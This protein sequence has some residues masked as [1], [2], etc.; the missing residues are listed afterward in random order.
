MPALLY[1]LLLFSPQAAFSYSFLGEEAALAAENPGYDFR[2]EFNRPLPQESFGFS[3]RQAEL[4]QKTR[5]FFVEELP[6]TRRR[7]APLKEALRAFFTRWERLPL[8]SAALISTAFS[9]LK[10][11]EKLPVCPPWGACLGLALL[12]PWISRLFSIL[13]H[14]ER[15]YVLRC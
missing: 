7:L 14:S 6:S 12:F 11:T 4:E 10:R 13:P 5:F 1:I 8:P 2:D 15:L 3:L 9:S